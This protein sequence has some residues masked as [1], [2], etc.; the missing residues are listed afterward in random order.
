MDR[1]LARYKFNK[2]LANRQDIWKM[3]HIFLVISFLLFVSYSLVEEQ[4]LKITFSITGIIATIIGIINTN[5]FIRRHRIAKE[6]INIWFSQYSEEE[7]TVL[8]MQ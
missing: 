4:F 3:V 8:Y 1:E 2:V 5:L 7:I 6:E